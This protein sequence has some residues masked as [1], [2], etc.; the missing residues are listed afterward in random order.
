MEVA[1]DGEFRKRFGDEMKRVKKEVLGGEKCWYLQLVFVHPD[2]QGLGV[3]QRLLEYGM[4]KAEEDGVVC[5]LESADKVCA[6]SRAPVDLALSLTCASGRTRIGRFRREPVLTDKSLNLWMFRPGVSTSR[7]G[8]RFLLGA[9]TTGLSG[10]L[11][12]GSQRRRNRS[13]RPV[14]REGEGSSLG[15][16]GQVGIPGLYIDRC[17]SRLLFFDQYAAKGWDEQRQH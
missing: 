10:R 8:L 6:T 7:M 1:V 11:S 12:R 14:S 9:S 5:Y 16:L 2:Y 4:R 17:I 3:A 13:S 15:E